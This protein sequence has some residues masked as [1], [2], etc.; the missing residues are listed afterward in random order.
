MND[1]ETPGVFDEGTSEVVT[2][3]MLMRI[4]D[5]LT[6]IARGINPTEAQAVYEAHMQGKILGPPPSFDMSDAVEDH[7]D[8]EDV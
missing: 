8:D 7:M 5:V 6:C 3:I 4:Y 2:A 1:E